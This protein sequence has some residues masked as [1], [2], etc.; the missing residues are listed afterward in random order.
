MEPRGCGRTIQGVS[1][2]PDDTDA[3][4]IS[5]AA[6]G[7]GEAFGALF[8]RH[9]DR[10]FRHVLHSAATVADAE[11]AVAITFL[12]AWRRR[13]S[14]RIVGGSALPW[15]LVTATHVAQN[16]A[17]SGRRYRSALERL[18]RDDTAGDHSERV[19]EEWESAARRRALHEALGRLSR[20]DREI[21][22]L[23]VVDEL[24]MDAAAEALGIPKGTVKS[25]LSRARS[26]LAELLR[27]DSVPSPHVDEVTP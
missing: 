14:V 27:Q 13:S 19:L 12:E 9:R 1:A 21:I 2:D 24:S 23:C 7:D 18:P 3:E 22:A 20:R 25:R 15:L 17:R 8:D 11:D 5:R 16:Q 4:L 26:R 10:V 6:T